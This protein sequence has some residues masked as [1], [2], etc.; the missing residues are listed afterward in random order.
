[1]C[2][3]GAHFRFLNTIEQNLN[4]LQRYKDFIKAENLFLPKDKLVLAVSGGVDSVVLCELCHQAGFDFMI[5]HCNFQLRGEES[6][7]DEKFV[8]KLG[9]KYKVQVIVKKFDTE[10]YAAEKKISI[11]VAARDLRYAWFEEVIGNRQYAISKGDTQTKKADCQLPIADCSMPGANCHLLT[12]HHANDNIETLLMN[13][14]RGTGLEGL[15]GIPGKVKERK[16]VRPLL[17]FKREEIEAFA[18]ENN[19]AWVED[20]SN[21]SS[22]YT[23]NYFRNELI[24]A[25]KKVY[26]QAED[27][28]LDTIH[29]F[30]QIENL[31]CVL[32]GDLKKKLC[33]QKG[34]DIHIPI[35]QLLGYKNESL[36]YEIIKDYGFG[37]KQVAEVLKLADSE[38]GHFI[39][40][41]LYRIIKHRHWFIIAAKQTQLS[42]NIII[43]E[44]DS[45]VVFPAGKL[46]IERTENLKPEPVNTVA[47][48]DTALI[49]FPLLLRKWKTGDYFY[50]LGMT[51]KKKLSRFFI[52]NKLSK[53]DKENI[54]VIEMNKKIIWVA[55]RRMDNRFKITE[56]TK[57]V[58]KIV[59]QNN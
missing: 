11:Q 24:P 9:E 27:N 34:S 1:V 12:A 46:R 23:R 20:S 25:L 18:K 57:E 50:P 54:W 16:I 38:S 52:D 28:L 15:K 48:F 26:P 3:L 10:Q 53:V 40:N 30:S 43:E 19:L 36:I 44:K 37:E 45:T 35:K 49:N 13:F 5:A 56:K 8:R 42:E 39:E 55:G 51:K 22:K 31:Y 21:K 58:L 14:F 7:R 59:L 41:N 6:E 47:Q 32:V 33:K 4:L 2:G 17:H 29:R